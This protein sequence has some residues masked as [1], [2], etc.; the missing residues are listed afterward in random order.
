MEPFSFIRSTVEFFDE[1]STSK[2]P[3]LTRE[4]DDELAFGAVRRMIED[5]RKTLAGVP[6]VTVR[7]MLRLA[8]SVLEEAVAS[9]KIR[10]NG[11]KEWT[12][13]YA[14]RVAHTELLPLVLGIFGYSELELGDDEAGIDVVGVTPQRL[15]AAYILRAT[16]SAI[17][18]NYTNGI[19]DLPM[20]YL[21]E[22]SVA[23]GFLRAMSDDSAFGMADV[24]NERFKRSRISVLTE[25][26]HVENRQMMAEVLAWWSEHKDDPGM[27]KDKA[28]SA[29]AGKIVPLKWRTVRD[30]LKGV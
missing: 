29:I 12:S 15:C 27:T 1:G 17:D 25:A 24:L 16:F 4:Y 26:R 14:L 19:D 10:L 8:D 5:A 28:A 2:K 21:M 22:A 6:E 11:G 23:Y 7:P 20:C 3:L 13:D 30:H 18:F 9:G